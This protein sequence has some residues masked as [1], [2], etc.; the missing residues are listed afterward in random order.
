METQETNMQESTTTKVTEVKEKTGFFSDWF[1]PYADGLAD[2]YLPEYIAAFGGLLLTFMVPSLLVQGLF[3]T[4]FYFLN[5]PQ[6]FPYYVA[7]ILFTSAYVGW[8]WWEMYHDDKDDG[9]IYEFSSQFLNKEE[10]E[11]K[12]FRFWL[13]LNYKPFNFEKTEESNEK[14]KE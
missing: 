8:R 2:S 14:A 6:D 5:R 3:N 11:R 9:L 1:A 13:R 4:I 12:K 10:T 7:F